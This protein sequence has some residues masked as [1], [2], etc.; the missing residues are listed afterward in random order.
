[1][2]VVHRIVQHQHA[3]QTHLQ[4]V[5]LKGVPDHPTINRGRYYRA[6]LVNLINNLFIQNNR[7]NHRIPKL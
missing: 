3:F 6:L 1:M 2:D 5:H 7:Y 4:Q